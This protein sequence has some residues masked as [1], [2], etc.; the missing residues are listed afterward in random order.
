MLCLNSS[1]WMSTD[2]QIIELCVEEGQ[3]IK[4]S[5]SSSNKCLFKSK[6]PRFINSKDDNSL[7]DNRR[8]FFAR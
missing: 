2:D 5:F 3:R 7:K 6:I 4:T 8:T 1:G